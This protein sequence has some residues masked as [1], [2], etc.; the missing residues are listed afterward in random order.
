MAKDIVFFP[1]AHVGGPTRLTQV[2]DL[3][4]SALARAGVALPPSFAEAID[5]TG[6]PLSGIDPIAIMVAEGARKQPCRILVP[7]AAAAV[8]V[9]AGLG[10]L[11]VA[12]TVAIAPPPTPTVTLTGAS[13]SATEGNSGAKLLTFTATRSS[14]TG[15]ATAPVAIALGTGMNGADFTGNAVPSGLAF[16]WADGATSAT[17]SISVNGDT[18]VESDESFTLTMT[19]PAGYAAGAIMS[20]T[21]IVLNDDSAAPTAWTPTGAFPAA[22]LAAWFDRSDAATITSSGGTVSAWADKS[23]R[24]RSLQQATAANRPVLAA[25]EIQFD[26]TNDMLADPALTLSNVTSANVPDGRGGRGVG[27]GFSLTHLC[28]DPLT[29]GLILANDG[30]ATDPSPI[31]SATPSLVFTDITGATKTG[32]LALSDARTVQGICVDPADFNYVWTARATASGGAAGALERVHR[33]S[34]AVS[35]SVAG[36]WNGMAVVTGDPL[37]EQLYFAVV[38]SGNLLRIEFRKR[39]GSL[40]RFADTGVSGGLDGLWW[41][42]ELKVFWAETSASTYAFDIQGERVGFVSTGSDFNRGEAAVRIGTKMLITHNGSYHA[43]GTP[44]AVPNLSKVFTYDVAGLEGLGRS[45]AYYTLFFL[46]RHADVPGANRAMISHD[47][48]LSGPGLAAFSSTGATG[49]TQYANTGHAG[50]AQQGV[51]AFAADISVRSVWAL[52]VDAVAETATLRCNGVQVGSPI[53]MPNLTGGRVAA[54]RLALGGQIALGVPERWSKLCLTEM[55]EVVSETALSLDIIQRAEG[56]LAH[57][58][59]M[60]TAVA[61]LD[62]GH[63]FKAAAPTLP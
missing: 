57:H 60:G 40:I 28:P 26:G 12:G 37:G 35:E 1:P 61:A 50:T 30:R 25:G 5:M 55:I 62:A 16:T 13:V 11:V 63:P 46:G 59:P 22:Q 8:I 17:L 27:L 38:P 29:G 2:D 15:A 53:A 47:N 42:A 23:G 10:A 21:G 51:A 19:P 48:P 41:D 31:G 34:G 56:Y 54:T 33:T 45:G 6:G 36:D 18:D 52:M 14:S 7:S 44:A 20:A 32:E 49:F 3:V 9:A 4:A 43:S 58:D 24:A 39:D